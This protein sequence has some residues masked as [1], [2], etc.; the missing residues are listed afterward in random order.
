VVIHAG[1][2]P[3]AAEYTGPEPIAKLLRRQPDLTVIVAHMGAP[4][5]AEFLGM[6]AAHERVY[7]DTTMIFTGWLGEFPD[8]SLPAL[9]DLGL[10]GKVLL[11]SDFPS[12][13]YPYARQIAGLAGLQFGQDWLRA[14]CWGNPMALFGKEIRTT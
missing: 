6:A 14:V 8:Q 2:A 11:G 10:R 5:F 13:P 1:H 4:D 7:L 9:N 3:V 12:I